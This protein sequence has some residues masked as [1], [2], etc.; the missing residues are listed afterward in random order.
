MKI[1]S[2][3]LAVLGLLMAG[4]A[5]AHTDFSPDFYGFTEGLSH[6]WTGIDHILAMFALGLGCRHRVDSYMPALF[7]LGMAAGGGL[8]FLEIDS[9]TVEGFIALSLLCIGGFLLGSVRLRGLWAAPLVLIFGIIHGYAH[10]AEIGADSHAMPYT[11]GFLISTAI[12]VICGRVAGYMVGKQSWLNR[13]VGSMA[14][15]AGLW[16][17][18]NLV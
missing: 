17:V 1:N 14:A 13:S 4:P 7:L 2:F 11:L 15:L 5:T 3:G 9:M 16:L 18:S 10:A 6:P 8:G 12:L